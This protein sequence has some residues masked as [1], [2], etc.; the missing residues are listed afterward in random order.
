[1][2]GSILQDLSYLQQ[3]IDQDPRSAKYRK[4]MKAL[5]EVVEDFSLINFATL[6]IQ[7]K[8]GVGNLVKLINKTNGYIFDGIKGKSSLYESE[9]DLNWLRLPP[10]EG[11]IR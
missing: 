5:C 2:E 6:D 1:M 8:E 4:L 7:D 10:I 9:L 11:A 3:H